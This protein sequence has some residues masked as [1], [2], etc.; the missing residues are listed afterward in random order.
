MTTEVFNE[1]LCVPN[2]SK[3][4]L[5]RAPVFTASGYGHHARQVASWL[6][7]KHRTGEITLTIEALNWG[8]TPWI[9]DSEAYD[10]LIGELQQLCTTLEPQYDVSFQLQLPNEW[11]PKLADTNIGMTAGVESDKCN[12]AWVLACNRMS[13]V[14]VPSTHVRR[15]LEASGQLTVPISVIPESFPQS[16]LVPQQEQ[17]E[18]SRR[19]DELPTKTNFLVF[20]QITGDAKTDRKNT[21]NTIK[22]L[23]E[24]FAEDRDVGIILKTNMSRNTRIDRNI[25]SSVVSNALSTFKRTT[26]VY[27]LHGNLSDTELMS[28]YCHPSVKALVSLTRGE[29]W[30][31]PILEA[32]ACDKPVIATDWSGHLDFMNQGK[33]IKIAYDLREI[34][35]ERVDNAIWIAGARWAEPRSDDFKMKIRKFRSSSAIPNQWAAELGKIIREKFNPGAVTAIYDRTFDYL[36]HAQKT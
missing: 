23:C 19:L 4:V 27:L 16:F 33:F 15:T 31:L 22:L 18:I 14:V 35:R 25:T 28:L 12:P 11:D 7:K 3:R 10:G 26:P 36:F 34:P 5:L 29:G 17:T 6:L 20:G 9:I 2:R 24:I 30:G 1:I 13:H 8:N 32:A 21:F